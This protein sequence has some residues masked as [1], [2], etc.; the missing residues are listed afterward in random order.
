MPEQVAITGDHVVHWYISLKVI[1]KT[2]SS[3]GKKVEE[4]NFFSGALPD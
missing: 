2:S 1:F 4:Q 3:V